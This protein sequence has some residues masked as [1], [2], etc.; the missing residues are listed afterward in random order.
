MQPGDLLGAALRAQ[1]A[2]AD[3]DLTDRL[4]VEKRTTH[5]LRGAVAV[6][7]GDHGTISTADPMPRL[8]SEVATVTGGGV[9]GLGAHAVHP[10]DGH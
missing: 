10:N 1:G 2:Q 4:G 7:A 3:L 8:G 5:D 6:G 9:S